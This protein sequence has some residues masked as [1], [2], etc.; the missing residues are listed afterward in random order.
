MSQAAVGLLSPGN[1]FHAD[2]LSREGA[3]LR[4]VVMSTVGRQSASISVPWE[5]S[6]RSG[7]SHVELEAVTA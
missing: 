1:V 5:V 2:W 6:R 3:R 4:S 7:A